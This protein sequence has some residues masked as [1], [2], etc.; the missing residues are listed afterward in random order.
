MIKYI[1]YALYSLLILWGQKAFTQTFN[2]SIDQLPSGEHVFVLC[3]I[4]NEQDD[5]IV[6]QIIYYHPI[7]NN[8]FA[9]IRVDSNGD[10]LT[11]PLTSNDYS[12]TIYKAL[13]IT[14]CSNHYYAITYTDSAFI[15][16]HKID[17]NSL[18]DFVTKINVLN[19]NTF[20]LIYST[21]NDNLFFGGNINYTMTGNGASSKGYIIDTNGIILDEVQFNASNYIDDYTH[22]AYTQDNNF[23]FIAVYDNNYDGESAYSKQMVARYDTNWNLINR[24]SIENENGN[25]AI[26]STKA[27]LT[28]SSCIMTS[29]YGIGNND[30]YARLKE[31]DLNTGQVIWSFVDSIGTLANSTNAMTDIHFGN[32]GSLYAMSSSFSSH[33][34]SDLRK[35]LGNTETWTRAKQVALYKWNK[36]RE[37]QWIRHIKHPEAKSASSNCIGN[38]LT[39]L[40]NNSIVIVGTY[41]PG[42]YDNVPSSSQQGWIVKTDSNG[43]IDGCPCT[44]W[45]TVGIEEVTSPNYISFEVYPN[46]TSSNVIYTDLQFSPSNKATIIPMS[47]G[48]GLQGKFEGNQL[49]INQKLTTGSYSIM[50]WDKGQL[51]SSKIIIQQ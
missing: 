24:I 28:D 51:Y 50:V 11:A 32:N 16:L 46:P 25:P 45:T 8:G 42:E 9:M 31:V 5:N 12:N 14:K 44:D 17:T 18:I 15:F 6:S 27:V 36:N 22:Y 30:Q 4:I 19:N 41:Y 29:A 1:K 33:D 10:I 49:S 34:S 23:L 7:Y 38:N 37:L 13:N 26:S 39:I 21:H 20:D 40:E 2:K 35:P 3:G 47:G 43:C 48:V